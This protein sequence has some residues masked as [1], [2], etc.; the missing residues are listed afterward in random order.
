M[1]LINAQSQQVGIVSIEDARAEAQQA[2]LDLVEISPQANPP[3]VKIIDWGK[4]RYEQQK[5]VAKSKSKQ[6]QVDVKQIRLGLKTDQHD[7]MVKQRSAE[8]F[9][10]A[11]HKVKVNLRFKGREIT[12]PDLGRAVLVRFAEQLSELATI[13]QDISLNGREL[14]LTLARK[15]DA[16]DK[17]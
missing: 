12:H 9:L 8:K 11:G 7:V 2:G 16:K 15:K 3:V 5:H 4:Y 14:S 17:D 1:R 10:N 6:K 13:E